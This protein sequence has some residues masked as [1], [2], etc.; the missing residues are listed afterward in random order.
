LEN[1]HLTQKLWTIIKRPLGTEGNLEESNISNLPQWNE[2]RIKRKKR[3][4]RREFWLNAHLDEYEIRV[5]MLDLGSD[6]NI[7]TKKT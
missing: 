4:T 2:S 1:E 7:L 5:F 6:V 3:R